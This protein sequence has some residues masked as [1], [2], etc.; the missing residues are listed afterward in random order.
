MRTR[1]N[2]TVVVLPPVVIHATAETGAGLFGL[3][4]DARVQLVDA[5]DEARVAEFIALGEALNVTT[6]ARVGKEELALAKEELRDTVNWFF[7]SEDEA[8]VMRPVVMFRLCTGTACK[9][10]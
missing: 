8:P 7:G 2:W 9:A 5:D 6:G 3:L 10:F 1:L 4:T